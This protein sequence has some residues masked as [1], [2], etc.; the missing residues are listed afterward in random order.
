MRQYSKRELYAAGEPLGDSVTRQ[1]AGR[2]VCG[3]GGGGSSS[4]STSSTTQNY[5]KRVAVETGV[6]LSSDSSTVT[7][8]TLD[9][10]IVQ[11]ALDTVATADATAGQGF[12]Q[13]LTL[14]DKL[15][16]TG[17]KVLETGQ[18]TTLAQVSALNA[19]AADAKGTIDQKTMIVLAVA[20]AAVLALRG[21]K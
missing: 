11:K 10:G 21:K 12:N 3:G 14:A 7:V 1:E 19:T 17:S 2:I 16:T 13:L 6:G 20:G 9:A 8:N 15:F 18:A 4:S 5:D